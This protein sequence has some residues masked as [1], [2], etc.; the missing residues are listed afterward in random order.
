MDKYGVSNVQALQKSELLSVN[1]SLSKLSGTL[2]KTG[3][4][5]QEIKRLELRRD[6]LSLE[7]QRQDEELTQQ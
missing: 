1:N 3:A 4:E 7:I 6:Q 5:M 2:E